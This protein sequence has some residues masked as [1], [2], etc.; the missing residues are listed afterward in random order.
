VTTNN[1][2]NTQMVQTRDGGSEGERPQRSQMARWNPFGLFDEFQDELA[3]LWSRPFGA[4]MT[5]P[6][7]LLA[8]VS[9]GTPRLDVYEQDGDLVVKAD[10]PGVKKEELQVELEDGD[11]VIQGET[12][13]ESEVKEDRYYRMERRIGHFYR[14]LP[15]PYDVKPDDV[16]ATLNDGVLE[17]RIP[18]P[19]ESR[20]EG[21]RIPVN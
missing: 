16:H 21:K 5:R 19:P 4:S 6:G 15:L 10:V 13:T 14:R 3:R 11:L 12:R 8:Q 2:Q 20:S 17:V 7:R 18:K 9:L 1:A